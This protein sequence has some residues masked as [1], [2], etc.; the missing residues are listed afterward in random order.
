MLD[1]DLRSLTDSQLQ[2]KKS[3][4]LTYLRTIA[5]PA[6]DDRTPWRTLTTRITETTRANTYQKIKEN[7]PPPTPPIARTP[8]SAPNLT[9][10]QDGG[11][12]HRRY[13][14]GVNITLTNDFDAIDVPDEP[15]PHDGYDAE[16]APVGA[17]ESDIAPSTGA[18]DF[19][20]PVRWSCLCIISLIFVS[21]FCMYYIT[22]RQ[23]YFDIVPV[24]A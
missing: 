16:S 19:H 6:N 24:S 3:H 1:K 17:L 2:L 23:I 9:T 8:N 10:R 20:R 5:K 14:I 21:V 15:F 13:D 18:V 4:D 11:H 7:E 12:R 22:H